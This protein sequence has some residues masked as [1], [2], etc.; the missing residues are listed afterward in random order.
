MGTAQSASTLEKLRATATRKRQSHHKLVIANRNITSLRG[1]STNCSRKPNDILWMLL[2]SLRQSIVDLTLLS[3]TMGGNSSTPA[4]S[5]YSILVRPQL[6]NCVDEWI[7]LGGRVCTLRL[8]LKL[9]N[10]RSSWDTSMI[11]L[12]TMPV[13][14]RE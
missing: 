14:G 10:P 11:M 3:W 13:C 1:K 2:A 9:T 7:A 5:Q 4:V 8:K 12:G 6:A